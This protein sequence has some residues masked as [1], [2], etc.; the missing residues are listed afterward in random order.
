MI[1][2]VA[3]VVIVSVLVDHGRTVVVPVSVLDDDGPVVR[4]ITLVVVV[5]V[6]VLVAVI[7]TVPVLVHDRR[8]V[9]VTVAVLDDHSPVVSSGELSV[10]NDDL[11]LRRTRKIKSDRAKGSSLKGK[12]WKRIL[13]PC[14]CRPF[15]MMVVSWWRSPSMIVVCK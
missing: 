9:V 12:E 7:V 10:V 13:T 1:V 5:S 4:G 11:V 3:V 2:L 8:V 15:W 14:R 6:V